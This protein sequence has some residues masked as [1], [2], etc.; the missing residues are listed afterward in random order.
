MEA[1]DIIASK[2]VVG[3]FDG[4]VAPWFFASFYQCQLAPDGKICI[5][6]PNGVDVMHVINQPNEKGLSCDF[7][8]HSIQLPTYNAF[9]M[10]NFPYFRLGAL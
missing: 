4:T 10:P 7:Q 9:S 3:I 8:Q 1:T 5:C 2:E 6:A